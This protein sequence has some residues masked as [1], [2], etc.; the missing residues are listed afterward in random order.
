M[1]YAE[2]AIVAA[3]IVLNG[4]LAMSELAI[5][6]ARPARLKTL[7]EQGVKGSRRALALTSDPGRVLSTVQIGITLVG[8]LAG[9][10]SGATL[11]LALK[12]ILISYGVPRPVADPAGFGIVVAIVT[13]LSV[14]VG[15]LVPKQIALRA[16]EA[17]AVVV[18]RPLAAMAYAA[19]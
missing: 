5:V 18:A 13:F 14:V 16:P 12:E 4:L 11:G 17:I 8:I 19:T 10:F 7:I 9:A 15:E 1:M 2:L 3:L 6:S